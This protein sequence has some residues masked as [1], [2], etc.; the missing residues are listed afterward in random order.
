MT[1]KYDQKLPG[2]IT[3]NWLRKSDKKMAKKNDYEKN[4]VQNWQKCRKNEI[5]NF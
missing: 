2:K 5:L 3:N 1:E 4:D